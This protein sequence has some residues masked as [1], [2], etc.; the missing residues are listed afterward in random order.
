MPILLL[1]GNHDDADGLR[2]HLGA[3][4]QPGEPLQYSERVGGLRLIA[5]D[6]RRSG[7]AD[8]ALGRERLTWLD[9]QLARD[10]T[11]PTL[12]AMHHPPVL[13]GVGALDDLGLAETDRQALGE[14]VGR[15]PQVRRIVAGHVHRTAI[16]ALG[17]CAVLV[18]PSSY[19]QLVL[20]LG[21][22]SEIALVREPP[23]FALHVLLDDELVSHVLPIGDYGPPFRI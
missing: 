22:S 12:V 6:T 5:S 13:T 9:G 8:G 16:G 21:P 14:L 3:P 4:G 18:C 19:L 20:D 17:G 11:T 2:A 10:R 23:G 1:A 15:N 7:R